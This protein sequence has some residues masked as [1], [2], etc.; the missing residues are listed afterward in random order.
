MEAKWNGGGWGKSEKKVEKER[1]G[2]R[3]EE[4]S[5]EAIGTFGLRSRG[6]A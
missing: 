1:E 4:T 2:G 6:T 5:K 3:K